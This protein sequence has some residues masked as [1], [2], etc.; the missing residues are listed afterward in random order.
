MTLIF[1]VRGLLCE[2]RLNSVNL[3][4]LVFIPLVMQGL[5]RSGASWGLT[6]SFVFEKG[7][8]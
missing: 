1:P 6:S 4:L 8:P 5:R 3:G 7:H 2:V